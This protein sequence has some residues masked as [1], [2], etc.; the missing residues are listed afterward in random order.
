MFCWIWI[1]YRIDWAKLDLSFD[2]MNRF[3]LLIQVLEIEQVFWFRIEILSLIRS[4]IHVWELTLE[5]F[6]C[7]FEFNTCFC[8]TNWIE[9]LN[10]FNHNIK[11]KSMCLSR[12]YVMLCYVMLWYVMLC[13][14]MLCYFYSFWHRFKWIHAKAIID[15]MKRENSQ[16]KEKLSFNA[17]ELLVMSSR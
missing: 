1:H 10:L 9:F 15:Y 3:K 6:W 17:S 11:I 4:K 13:Y 5:T 12:H 14:V 7:D 16:E 8:A 2:D